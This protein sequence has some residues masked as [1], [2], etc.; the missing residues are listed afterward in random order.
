MKDGIKLLTQCL[1]AT[2][3]VSICMEN[4]WI[5]SDYVADVSYDMFWKLYSA[6]FV[7]VLFIMFY[8]GA[9]GRYKME[10]KV[11][12]DESPSGCAKQISE[13]DNN[14]SNQCNNNR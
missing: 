7:L 11:Y 5:L 10:I 2:I 14:E 9:T 4:G 1:I 8:R 12:K 3:L 6:I 13:E